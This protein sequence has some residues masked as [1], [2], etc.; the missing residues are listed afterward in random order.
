LLLP[1]RFDI[2]A[3]VKGEK[4]EVLH[5]EDAFYPFDVL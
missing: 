3:L 1:A 5:I 4:F 2:V